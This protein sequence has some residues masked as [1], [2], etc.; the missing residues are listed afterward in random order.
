MC[1]SDLAERDVRRFLPQA[2]PLQRFENAIDPAGLAG[3]SAAAPA[4]RARLGLPRDARLREAAYAAVEPLLDVCQ[5]PSAAA[6]FIVRQTIEEGAPPDRQGAPAA[7]RSACP[8]HGWGHQAQGSCRLQHSV[9]WTR[10]AF[11][12]F[13][14][15]PG[16]PVL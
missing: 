9:C 6:F 3:A 7:R 15:I 14:A 10:R 16:S 5:D 4:A 2:V 1:S 13:A 12:S 8:V 11:Q